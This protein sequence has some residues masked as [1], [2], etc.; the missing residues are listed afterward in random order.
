MSETRSVSS[1]IAHSNR[2]DYSACGAQ[3][4]GVESTGVNSACGA[5]SAAVESTGVINAN[6]TTVERTATVSTTEGV[7][8]NARKIFEAEKAAD[9]L[10]NSMR[11]V[12]I[13]RSGKRNLD[14]VNA[15]C[16]VMN[17]SVENLQSVD[18][19]KS[20]KVASG[21]I[22]VINDSKIG[23][24]IAH[25]NLRIYII[26]HVDENLLACSVSRN[27]KDGECDKQFNE[28]IGMLGGKTE[29]IYDRDTGRRFIEIKLDGGKLL[30][31]RLPGESPFTNNV[32]FN[33]T[34]GK[35]WTI[36]GNCKGFDQFFPQPIEFN[37]LSNRSVESKESGQ[38]IVDNRSA[39]AARKSE[40]KFE[41][42]NI[43]NC[44]RKIE[45][46]RNAFFE[47][48]IDKLH[49]PERNVTYT[50]KWKAIYQKN[51]GNI[52]LSNTASYI[53]RFD[54]VTE[55][56]ESLLLQASERERKGQPR[57]IQPSEVEPQLEGQV[58]TEKSLFETVRDGLKNLY[59]R[60]KS[61]W[62][63]SKST[64][65]NSADFLG[66]GS[67]LSVDSGIPLETP[68][69]PADKKGPRSLE[70]TGGCFLLYER[71]R[72]KLMEII[73]EQAHSTAPGDL[74]G[75][76]ENSGVNENLQENENLFQE[77]KNPAA[78]N[79]GK[80]LEDNQKNRTELKKR[81]KE[82][83]KKV[84]EMRP[85]CEELK[86][87]YEKCREEIGK[88]EEWIATLNGEILAKAGKDGMPSYSAVRT[89]IE[90]A[91][92]EL[93]KLKNFY[94][95]T[96]GNATID[97]MDFNRIGG[98]G[99]GNYNMGAF[100]GV[101]EVEKELDRV[102]GELEKVTG[103]LRDLEL[104]NERLKAENERL[105]AEKLEKERLEKERLER[106]DR[107]PINLEHLNY[108]STAKGICDKA[109]A[110]MED[111]DRILEET[112]RAAEE[113]NRIKKELDDFLE[114][115]KVNNQR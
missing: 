19:K 82:L 64:A 3:S 53:E 33:T 79:L 105:V 101:S 23:K 94:C 21:T 71:T 78:E 44:I 43:D 9:R 85:L 42:S 88:M 50:E 92:K 28:F 8:A 27:M 1:D 55:F 87:L 70:T 96:P 57:E 37:G 89:C 12:K 39:P 41:F 100:W 67:A 91:R 32:K 84:E 90:A 76:D 54:A 68:I 77:Q 61:L 107:S 5:Q 95:V 24:V 60:F 112:S 38:A 48:E 103:K 80:K 18:E 62:N 93:E 63:D 98:A 36:E 108:E 111:V 104:E 52:M 6:F 81:E 20:N 75:T 99:L 34:S 47:S 25:K 106:L 51:S 83:K 72:N 113:A 16:K 114:S 58:S 40:M 31:V 66:E 56:G 69:D 110:S 22:S 11:D 74:K 35:E 30:K 86:F 59:S 109:L 10:I 46:N 17:T 26:S 102:E 2:G 4:A 45:E 13:V 15:L 73:S 97:S 7:P 14:C 29:I 49:K 65:E 115:L